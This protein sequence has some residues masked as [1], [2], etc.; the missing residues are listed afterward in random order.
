MFYVYFKREWAPTGEIA[1]AEKL[2]AAIERATEEVDLGSTDVEV[3]DQYGEV[4]FEFEDE[5]L[6]EEA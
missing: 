5:L 6:L 4:A 1:V 3:Y 2:E